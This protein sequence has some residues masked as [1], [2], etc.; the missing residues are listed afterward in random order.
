MKH[1]RYFLTSLLAVLSLVSTVAH[2]VTVTDSHGQFHID[3][4]PKRIVALEFSF[5]DALASV[6]VSPIGIA[7]DNDPDRLLPGVQ[8]KLSEWH[9]VGTRSQPSLEV[10]AFLK[11]DLIIADVDRHSGIYADLNKIAPTLLLPSR[12]ETYES[13]LQSAAI[14]GKVVG[15]NHEMTERLKQHQ[16]LMAEYKTRLAKAGLSQAYVQ[17]GV[18]R[19]NGF[20]AHSRESYAGGVIRSLGLKGSTALK[21]ENASRQISLEQLLGLNPDYL[22]I[23]DY[24]SNSIIKKWEQ[25]PLWKVLTAVQQQHLY[26]VDGNLWARCRGI[27]AAEYMAQDLM[28]LIPEQ[29]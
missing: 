23:G 27:M 29:E 5:V 19:E 17:F 11:P 26:H 28:Q 24:S 1:L 25:Q 4:Q 9:S 6:N 8:K 13:N 16:E 10:I 12:R 2:A 7:D 14:I 20:Y 3:Y 22:V 21:N 18:A 15:K